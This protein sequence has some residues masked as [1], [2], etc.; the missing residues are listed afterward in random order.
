MATSTDVLVGIDH[1]VLAVEDPDATAGQLEE[2]LGLRAG[3]GGRHDALG[4]FNRLVWLGDSYVELIGVFDS[5]LAA[6]SWLG[7]PVMAAIERG[8]GLATWAVAVDDLDAQLRWLPPDAGFAGP[9]DGERR[10]ED[11]RV[12]RWRLAHP[13]ALSPTGPFLIEHDVSGAEW[14]P[15]ERSARAAEQHPVGG[16][17]RLASL[18]VA[19]DNPAVAAGR[20]RR[21]LATSAEP[22]GRA[23]VRIVLGR[24]ELRVVLARPRGAAGVELMADVALRRRSTMVGDCEIRLGGIALPPRDSAAAANDGAGDDAGSGAH[25]DSATDV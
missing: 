8:G 18:E 12:V 19:T 3:G 24:Q 25:R 6:R 2:K 15:D 5:E 13:P 11:G 17:V 21:L 4:T 14:T 7:P 22:A 23:A 9:L 16:R 10:R 1:V 20:L